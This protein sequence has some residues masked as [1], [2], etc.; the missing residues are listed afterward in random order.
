MAL[1]AAGPHGLAAG[2]HSGVGGGKATIFNDPNGILAV[3]AYWY[4]LRSNMSATNLV[5][6]TRR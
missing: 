1:V 6:P 2:G 5:E 4:A 3:D